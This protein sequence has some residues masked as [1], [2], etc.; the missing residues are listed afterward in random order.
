MRKE[1][2]EKRGKTLDREMNYGIFIH[3]Y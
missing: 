1:W 3:I 2:K